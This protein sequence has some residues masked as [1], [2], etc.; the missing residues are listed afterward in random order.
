MAT[1]TSNKHTLKDSPS[2]G[3]G[4]TYGLHN[5]IV[6][7]YLLVMFSFFTLFL[8]NKYGNS[9]HDKF[10][11]YLALSGAMI[12]LA[13]VMYFVGSSE[14]TQNGGSVSLLFKPVTATD[15]AF[16]CF[17]VF[18]LIST[19]FSKYFP[20]NIIAEFWAKGIARNNG[21]LLLLV[22]ALVYFIITRMYVY[23]DYVIAVY[24]I[25]SCIIALLTVLNF[26]YIDPLGLLN[27]YDADTAKDFGSTIG[28]KN[29]IASYMAM[30]LPIAMMT[31]AINTKRYMKIL[32]GVS[33]AFAYTGA[34]AANS[35]SVFLGLIVAVPV[36]AI[37]CA[38]RYDHMMYYVLG[39]GIMLVSG[40][41]LRFL[42]F[43]L[44]DKGFE[45]M[46]SFLIH[47]GYVYIPAALFI[48]LFAAMLLLKGRLEPH[49][50]AK[51]IF[52]GL[53]A[54]TVLA[55]G[56][57]LGAILYFSLADTTTELGSFERLLRFNDSWGTHRGFMWIRA[58][59]EYGKFD[60]F[61]IMFGA[62][63]DTAYFVLEPHFAELSARFGDGSTN[64]V[65]NEYLNYLVTQ[66]ALGLIS[67]LSII[68]AVCVRAARRAKRN[69]Y[70]LI[71]ISAVI[72]YAAQATVNLYQPITTPLFFIFLSIAEA[73]NRQNEIGRTQL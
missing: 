69:P 7:Y 23:K 20:D 11:L 41:L 19:V 51:G 70:T 59:Q 14:L 48:A 18:A 4:G 37:F 21:M 58:M 15:I 61:R 31:L 24:L 42:S 67:Y 6:S 72:C 16:L 47:S 17:L 3:G 39:M 40:K 10:Y 71:F 30:F 57:M 33:V 32:A 50:P 60:F 26:F 28:N 44:Q 9:R 29:T 62:G 68:G 63:P 66:G 12:I 49:Y 34:L 35:S 38:K 54:V 53:I 64:C 27:G 8:T 56:G 13:G 36:M 25:F 5:S 65:H 45:F 2:R 73:L 22:Y 1:K 52:I 55:L 43:F 46:Q